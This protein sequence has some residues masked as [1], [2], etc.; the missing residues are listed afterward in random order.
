[1]KKLIWI[2]LIS[3]LAIACNN[4]DNKADAYGNFEATEVMVSSLAQGEILSLTIKEGQQLDADII[5]GL[6]DTVDLSLKKRQL[7]RGKDAV[8]TGL[9]TI[10]AQQDVLL[11]QK[12]N[13]LVDKARVDK[14][15]KDGAATQKQRDD[16]NG[17]LDLLEAQI[18]SANSQKDR[19]MAEAETIEAQIDQVME[20]LQKCRI[21]NPTN[22]TI[23]IKY[24]EAGEVAV[25]GK[26]LYK[27]ADLRQMELK[28][29][30]SGIQLPHIKLGQEVEVQI[31]NT[32]KENS[33]MK[34]QIT[35]ISSTAEFTPKTIQTKDE[36][37]NL[38]Y[39]VKI[40]VANDGSVKIGMPGQVNF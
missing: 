31:D 10:N 5:V 7:Q 32:K 16:I 19:I 15:Y 40:R 20:G 17:A 11:Q 33:S 37:V 35:W 26:P 34:G 4:N 39:A 23:L 22:G 25:M 1:M 6:I 30:V 2:I 36:R 13:L 28:V 14:L 12:K 21:N 8:Y 29:Y 9:V 3:T 18:I 24:A 38:V 27:I